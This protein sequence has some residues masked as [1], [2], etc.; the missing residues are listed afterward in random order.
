VVVLLGFGSDEESAVWPM[1]EHFFC[2]VAIAVDEPM[3]LL[4]LGHRVATLRHVY[5]LSARRTTVTKQNMPLNTWI[6]HNG[7]L[8]HTH[9]HTPSKGNKKESQIKVPVAK[10]SN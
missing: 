7:K 6:Q 3:V 10:S 9:K 8:H 2:F 4:Q 1:N 5:G